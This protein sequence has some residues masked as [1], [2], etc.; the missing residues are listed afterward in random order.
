MESSNLI[1]Q[2]VIGNFIKELYKER[3][4]RRGKPDNPYV[5]SPPPRVGGG[6]GGWGLFNWLAIC[7]GAAQVS[8]LSAI[9]G[10]VQGIFF[11]KFGVLQGMLF[12]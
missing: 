4:K 3:R 9:L 12:E 10:I 1:A 2:K 8:V 7:V 11:L 5:S 6:V